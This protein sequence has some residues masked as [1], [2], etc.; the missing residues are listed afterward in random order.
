MDQFCTHLDNA[1]C[2][3]HSFQGENMLT[4]RRLTS[5]IVDVPHR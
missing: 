5:T 4:Y 1:F 3:I 2:D